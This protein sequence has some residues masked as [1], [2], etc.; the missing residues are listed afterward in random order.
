MNVA[1]DSAVTAWTAV[2]DEFEAALGRQERYLDAVG[3]PGASPDV[4][5]PFLV[6]DD[7]PAMPPQ[8]ADRAR[9]LLARNGE[10]VD[11]ARRR[12][13][14]TRPRSAPPMHRHR[15]AASS[16]AFERWA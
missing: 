9:T 15:A 2:L 13:E 1:D 16:V 5:I 4:P 11:R 8:V 3:L 10:V 14:E 12:S 7:L 6:P